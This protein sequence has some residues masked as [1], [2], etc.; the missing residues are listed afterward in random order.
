MQ[1]FV[2]VDVYQ[3]VEGCFYIEGSNPTQDI[4]KSR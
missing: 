2:D 3:T 4:G 1:I